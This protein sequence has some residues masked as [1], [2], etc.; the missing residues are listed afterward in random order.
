MNISKETFSALI[1]LFKD[2]SPEQAQELYLEVREQGFGDINSAF[3]I[4]D[5]VS[6]LFKEDFQEFIIYLLDSL[7]D[8]VDFNGGLDEHLEKVFSI[9]A[10]LARLEF[11]AYTSAGFTVEQAMT[12][13]TSGS[14]FNVN[15][16]T[17]GN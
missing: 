15:L 7:F 17:F 16:P 8:L 14:K 3:K 10:K 11:D 4:Y 5:L 12:L 13:L 2:L 6:D 1:G 9:K